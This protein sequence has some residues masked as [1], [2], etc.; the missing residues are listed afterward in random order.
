MAAASDLQPTHGADSRRAQ[1][2]RPRQASCLSRGRSSPQRNTHITCLDTYMR[3]AVYTDCGAVRNHCRAE[4]PRDIEPSGLVP[5]VSGRNRAA[6]SYVPADSIKTPARFAR[7]WFRRIHCGSAAPCLSTE[8]RTAS[9]AGCLAGPV[10]PVLVRSRGCARTPPR[11]D[12]SRPHGPSTAR[13][14]NTTK[15]EN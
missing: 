6:T 2:T 5:T 14:I 15:K 7:S 9:G 10:P 11:S 8:T 4:P 13:I 1:S 3:L 12:A